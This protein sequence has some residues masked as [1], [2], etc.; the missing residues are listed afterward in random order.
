ML[1]I[2]SLNQSSDA[3]D[4][5]DRISKLNLSDDEKNVLFIATQLTPESSKIF[6]ISSERRKELF[7]HELQRLADL[8][9]IGSRNPST[10]LI[11]EK[12]KNFHKIDSEE[13]KK[14]A[15]DLYKKVEN[16]EIDVL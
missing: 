5:I 7:L 4:I 15:A 3:L 14:I 6:Q 16:S 11:K 2:Q 1:V 9:Y 8:G 10:E 12:L 13:I